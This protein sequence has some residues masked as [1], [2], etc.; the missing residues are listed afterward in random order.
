MD[1]LQKQLLEA[2]IAREAA[3]EKVRF[4]RAVIAGIQAGEQ[5]AKQKA[6]AEAQ[7]TE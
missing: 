6:A 3:D 1:D 2:Y 5:A 4:L 7:P